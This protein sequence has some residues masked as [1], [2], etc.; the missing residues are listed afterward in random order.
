MAS[1]KVTKPATLSNGTVIKVPAYL[2]AGERVLVDTTT[3]D[4]VKRVSK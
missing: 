3:G 1:G 2:E 4:F